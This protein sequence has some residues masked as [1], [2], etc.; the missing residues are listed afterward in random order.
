M[1]LKW[2]KKHT[3]HRVSHKFKN[4][5]VVAYKIYKD[6]TQ[7]GKISRVD[8]MFIHRL[9]HMGR[10]IVTSSIGMTDDQVANTIFYNQ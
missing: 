2:F 8:N 9:K 5:K 7:R 3:S 4:G 1:E 6:Y 10:A